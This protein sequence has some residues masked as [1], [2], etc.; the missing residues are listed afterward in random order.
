[1][2]MS[3]SVPWALA[4]AIMTPIA[5]SSVAC[6]HAAASVDDGTVLTPY[7]AVQETLARDSI[8]D[9]P[10]LGAAIVRAAE[11]HTN[12]PGVAEIVQG[13]GRIAAQDIATARAAFLTISTG[14]IASLRAD[15]A[16]QPG[17][18]IVHCPM[19]FGGKGGSWVQK[20][21]PIRNPYEGAM[22]LTCGAKVPWNEAETRGP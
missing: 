7:L 21:G 17:H 12:E 14:V 2:R 9:L 5:A 8:E 11:G 6:E 18:M 1:M 15:A 20:T 19:T 10:R 13:A 22:M 4:I 3:R 16:K